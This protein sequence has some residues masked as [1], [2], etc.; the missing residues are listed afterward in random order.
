[1]EIIQS[2]YDGTMPFEELFDSFLFDYANE[3][4]N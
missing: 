2:E 1:M 3:M 4:T